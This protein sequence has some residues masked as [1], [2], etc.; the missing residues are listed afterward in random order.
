MKPRKCVEQK[1]KN[2]AHDLKVMEGMEEVNKRNEAR[3]FYTRA[4]E[5]K[6]GFQ[7]RM[8]AYKERDNNLIGNDRLVMERRKQNF[9]GTLNIK[10]DVEIRE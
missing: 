4:R 1:K 5:I 2:G 10:D 3:K 9:C 7:P 6:A 8:S